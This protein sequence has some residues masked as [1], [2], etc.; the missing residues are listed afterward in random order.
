MVSIVIAAHN[1]EAVIGSCLEAL[2]RATGPD[3]EIIVSANGCI[4]RTAEIARDHGAIVVDRSTPG[5]PEALNAGDEHATGFPRVYLD[6]D[7]RVPAHGVARLE[8]LLEGGA[9]A[10]VPRRRVETSGRPLA[11]RAYF[12]INGRLPAFRDGLFGRGMIALS[13]TGR[14]RFGQ[15][16]SL[17]AD[18]LFLDAQ[19]SSAEKA[20]ADDVVVVVEA[21]RTTRALVNRLVRVRRGNAEMRSAAATGAVSGAVRESDRWAWLREVVLPHPHLAFAAVAYLMI[22]LTAALRARGTRRGE[23]SWGRDE[24]TRV[25]HTTWIET[26]R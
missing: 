10:A 6:A 19:F 2:R 17:T 20:E 25:A 16:P 4:D 22:T 14:R 21:P 26:A 9:L 1:E 7:I 12:A 18:D 3:A 8:R 15:F 13:E 23:G 11:V 5:K 24:S